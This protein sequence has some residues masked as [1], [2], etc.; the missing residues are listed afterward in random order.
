M[1]TKAKTSDPRD[2]SRKVVQTPTRVEADSN[3]RSRFAPLIAVVVLAVSAA[4]LPR[5]SLRALDLIG[6]AVCH[7][8]PE[9]SFFVG[10][11]QLPVCA[12][13]TG[14]FSGALLGIVGFCLALRVRAAQ[15]PKRPFLFVFAAFFLAW[16]FDGF[17]S[18]VA[19]AT[20]SPLVYQPQNWLRLTTGA[21][22]GVTLSA[23]VVPLFNQGVWRNNTA[24][25]SVTSW[26]DLAWLALIGL[27]IIAVVL[28]QPSFLYGPIAAISSV[29]A[30]ALLVIVNGMLVLIVMKRHGQIERWSQLI[31]PAIAGLFFAITEIL[32]ID[33]LRAALTESLGLPW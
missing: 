12:R 15:F 5:D 32:V 16:A 20:G 3:D 17:N 8:I 28:W 30:L 18:Y 31:F 27:G 4:L 22:M 13:D 23:F 26:R 10:G 6:Y 29:G 9:R 1:K 24:V 2:Q 19:L 7:R 25:P 21:L 14:M 11:M 33:V